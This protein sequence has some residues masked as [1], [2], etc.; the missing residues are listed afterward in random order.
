MMKT[1]YRRA[2]SGPKARIF[3]YLLLLLL[4]L[5]AADYG[6][7][8][9]DTRQLDQETKLDRFLTRKMTKAGLIGLQVAWVTEDHIWQ[10]NYGLQEYG[11]DKRVNENTL[12]MIASCSKPVVALGILKLVDQGKLQLDD[13]VNSYLPFP[14]VNPHFPEEEITFRMLLTHFSSIKDNWEVLTPLY[15][16]EE[17]GDSP[18]SL[19]EFLPDYLATAGPY[20]DPEANFLAQPVASEYS[21]CNVGYAL[22][23]YLIER[24]SGQ[25][26]ADFMQA[27]IFAPLG[28][29][30]AYW[31]LADI[32]HDNIAQPHELPSKSNELASPKLFKHYGYADYPSGQIRTTA[33]D[34]GRFLQLMLQ[35]G[36]VN[37]TPFISKEL[38]EEFLRIQYPAIDKHQAVAWNYNEF[39]NFIYYLLMPR[40]PSHT[41]GDPGVATAVS[42]DPENGIGAIIFTNSPPVR[43]ID[44]KRFY[45][46]IMKRLLKEAKR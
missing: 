27:E 19:D 43:F 10:G 42:F 26:F 13:P 24:V 12:F 21:Y 29:N 7:C 8:Q 4:V 20:Y 41:G 46:E 37:D 36:M 45:Q 44:Q 31:F 9:T 32:P 25:A 14:I 28:M 2:S 22:L 18:L 23:G 30:D 11:T 6:A 38:I 15:T 17:G 34:Y 1:L 33:S 3:P 35:Q 5:G 39:D 40:L 16:T